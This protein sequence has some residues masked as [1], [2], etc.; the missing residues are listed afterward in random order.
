MGEKAFQSR[1]VTR[2]FSLTARCT[3]RIIGSMKYAVCFFS[4]IL[5]VAV[6]GCGGGSN[7]PVS[8]TNTPQ[9]AGISPQSGSAGTFVQI[10]GAY[11]GAQQGASIVSY[12]NE[13]CVISS[14][15][16]TLIACTIP[17]TA[18]TSGTF[19]VT[20]GGKSSAASMQFIYNAPQIMSISPSS[21]V[22][23]TGVTISGFGFGVQTVYSRILL[24]NNYAEITSWSNTVITCKIPQNMTNGSVTP[25]VYIDSSY[26]ISG[27]DK[28]FNCLVP[29]IT[30]VISNSGSSGH[31]VGAELK[32][33]GQGFGSYQGEIDL[34]MNFGGKPVSHQWISSNALTFRV[35]TDASVGFNT[36]A[37]LVNNKTYSQTSWEIKAPE[38]DAPSLTT[39]YDQYATVTL[40]GRNFG[41]SQSE[42][43]G[44][45]KTYLTINGTKVD[46]FSSWSDT[47]ISFSNPLDPSWNDP[48]VP[49]YLYVGDIQSGV[50]YIKVK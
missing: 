1:P 26:Y 3:A 44:R 16:D 6:L 32:V 31:N 7:N 40:T 28:T 49:I 12:N 24:G 17:N 18:R 43:G 20:V 36:V 39:T 9:I 48:K 37:I 50:V 45:T 15:S 47:S 8:L 10:W 19:I 42:S 14:W 11:F 46:S 29:Y 4:A 34:A 27:A 30:G 5:I 21:G 33:N 13:P 23:G 38:I 25:I 22:P 41:S 35:P 2:I